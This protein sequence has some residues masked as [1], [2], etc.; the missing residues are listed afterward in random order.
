MSTAPSCR[1]TTW[2]ST[3]TE[4]TARAPLPLRS[5]SPRARIGVSCGLGLL[6]LAALPGATRA[7]IVEEIVAKVNNRIVTKS[8]FEERSQYILSQIYKDHSGADLDRQVKEAQDTMLANMITELLLIER[9]HSLLDLEKVRK[10]LVDDFRKQQ[11][12][13]NDD[14]LEKLLKEQNLTRKDLEEQLVRLAVPG[15]VINYE[16]K[17]KISVSEREIKDYYDQHIKDYETPPTVTFRE[18]VL[19]YEPVTQKEALLRAQ[20]IVR[21]SKGGA[22]FQDLVQRH[23]EAGTKEAGGVLDPMK[24]S[25]LQPEIAKVAFALDVGEV[26]EPIDTGKSFQI[27]RVEAKTPRIV[28]ALAEAHDAIYDAIREKKFHP[29]YDAYLKKL[30][31]ESHVEVTSKYESLLVVSPLKP[32]PGG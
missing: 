26:S 23:S 14:D 6:L 29:R 19:F 21:E 31:Q 17:R 13:E 3:R 8:E 10:N 28:K 11:K 1:S 30:W 15:E 25:D 5:H 7:A 27:I 16:V 24:A 4:V 20:G 2:A 22:D 12:I 9:A 32:R 18:I